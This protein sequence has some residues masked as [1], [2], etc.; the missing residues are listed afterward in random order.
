MIVLSKCFTC[1]YGIHRMETY[2]AQLWRAYLGLI[3][4]LTLSPL[5]KQLPQLLIPRK[6]CPSI[7][8]GVRPRLATFPFQPAF[9]ISFP[10]SLPEPMVLPNGIPCL[11]NISPALCPRVFAFYVPSHLWVRGHAFI[12]P[13]QLASKQAE[14]QRGWAPSPRTLLG[15]GMWVQLLG[16]IGR[17]EVQLRQE[18]VR[19][20]Q[21][22]CYIQVCGP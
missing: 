3:S 20:R 22:V 19:P 16:D 13:A 17:S 4:K 12:P 18:E 14:G 11:S 21:P 8:C 10:T 9:F 1:Y 7:V 5:I 15:L 2:F 6:G